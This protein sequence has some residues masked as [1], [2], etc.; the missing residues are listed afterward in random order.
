MFLP[1]SV[2]LAKALGGAMKRLFLLIVLTI[3]LVA[4]VLSD[5]QAGQDASNRGDYATAFREWKP[6]AEAGDADAQ[7]NLGYLYEKGRGVPKDFA[8]AMKWYGKAAKQGDARALGNIGYLYEK[9]LGVAKD[10]AE[11]FKWYQKA[12]KLGLA[13]AQN[14]LGVYYRKGLGVTKDINKALS[15]FRAAAEKGSVLAQMNLGTMYTKGE[16][17]VKDF[18]EAPKW[19]RDAANQNHPGA[20]ALLGY[21]HEKGLGVPQDYAQALTWYREAILKGNKFAAKAVARMEGDPEI[22]RQMR[23]DEEQRQAELQRL[24]EEYRVGEER[25]RKEKRAALKE[26][27]RRIRLYSQDDTVAFMGALFYLPLAALLFLLPLRKKFE[28]ATKRVA[29]ALGR[30]IGRQPR[31]SFLFTLGIFTLAVGAIQIITLSVFGERPCGAG[32]WAGVGYGLIVA[33]VLIV[34]PCCISEFPK[35][36][37]WYVP[38]AVL[39]CVFML[40]CGWFLLASY[41][42]STGNPCPEYVLTGIKTLLVIALGEWLLVRARPYSKQSEVTKPEMD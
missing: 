38:V 36:S 39:G 32:G 25:S 40:F 24:A 30:F 17:V 33:G 7:Y 21:F 42:F 4:P 20:K 9:G 31:S 29:N 26:E 18:T 3:G 14:N 35:N 2:E 16:G 5:F 41:A 11:A 34:G 8:E 10:Y 23:K 22:A 19:Y 12:A 1:H 15:L 6:L 13:V 28:P 37:K 27:F